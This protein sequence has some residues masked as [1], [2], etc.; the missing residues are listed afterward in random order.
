MEPANDPNI[1]PTASQFAKPDTAD[2]HDLKERI[3]AC[4]RD[5]IPDLQRIHVTAFGSTVVI[6]GQLRS[7]N[8]KRLSLECCRHVPGVIRVI[9]ELIVADDSP[10]GHDSEEDPS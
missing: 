4:L 1:T 3:M 9:D 10:V 5:R 7:P 8:E 6:R 2:S